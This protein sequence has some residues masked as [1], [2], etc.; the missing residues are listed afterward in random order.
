MNREMSAPDARRGLSL[1]KQQET[2]NCKKDD[3]EQAKHT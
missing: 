3:R 2:G 1:L